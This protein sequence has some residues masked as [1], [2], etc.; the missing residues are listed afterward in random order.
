MAAVAADAIAGKRE[1]HRSSLSMRKRRSDAAFFL[2][3]IL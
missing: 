1:H 2:R 3:R